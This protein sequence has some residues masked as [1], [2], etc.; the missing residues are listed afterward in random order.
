[1]TA[2][3][4]DP[5]HGRSAPT[6][7][8]STANL[9]EAMPGVLTPLGWSVWGPAAEIGARAAFHSMGAIPGPER[10]V[11]GR[12]EDRFINIFFGRPAARVDYLASIGDRMPGTSSE[13]I[14]T[15]L[16]GSV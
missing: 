10:R 3:P 7:Y 1:M 4:P 14:V 15:Q 8:W 6:S 5:I 2:A 11:P 13:A 16:L 12:E 9:A